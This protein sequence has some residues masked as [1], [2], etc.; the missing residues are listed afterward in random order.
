MEDLLAGST[1]GRRYVFGGLDQTTV[2]IDARVN[3][4]ITP[5]LSLQ[6]Y[7]EPFISTGDYR[8]LKELE[9]PR[10]FDFLEYGKDIGTVSPGPGESLL[11]NAVLRWE[12]RQGST[13]YLVWQQPR[14]N[15]VIGRDLDRI[16]NWVG[17]FDLVRDVGDMFGTRP[18]NIFA[19][20]L[21]YWLNP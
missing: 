2:Y 16:S 7:V 10:T 18:D 8:Q 17:D 9:R 5:T 3:V 15:S 1:Y 11:G 4:T 13:L 14:I 21:N 19:L 12:W 6:L 20:K